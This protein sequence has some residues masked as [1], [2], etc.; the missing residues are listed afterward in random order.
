[1]SFFLGDS[2]I[3]TAEKSIRVVAK[4]IQSNGFPRGLTANAVFIF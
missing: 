4:N 3:D 2:E 1:M